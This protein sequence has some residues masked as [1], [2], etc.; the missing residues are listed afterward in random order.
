ML[1]DL[2]EHFQNM[3]IFGVELEDQMLLIIKK[4]LL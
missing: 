4:S 3:P 2:S 1:V